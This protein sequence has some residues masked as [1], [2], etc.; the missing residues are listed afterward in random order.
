MAG[1]SPVR[2]VGKHA[3][4]LLCID[5]QAAYLPARKAFLQSRGYEVFTAASGPE[6]LALLKQHRIDC[7]VLDYR[8]PVMD[9][10]EVAREIRRTRP[11][12]PIVMFS[13][14]PQE[15]PS[16][17]RAL[18]DAL[19]LKGTNLS[20]LLDALDELLPRLALR[21]RPS[22]AVKDRPGTRGSHTGR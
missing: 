20:A 19:A 8:M 1:G 7:V 9:G 15:I 18:V 10:A 16:P 14:F 3:F 21:P 6:G 13:G 4:T 5:D 11:N 12:L 2:R 17:V 22:T